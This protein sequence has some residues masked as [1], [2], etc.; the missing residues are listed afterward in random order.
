MLCIFSGPTRTIK[1]IKG[2]KP[3]RLD[4]GECQKN[5]HSKVGDCEHSPAIQERK[6]GCFKL[7]LVKETLAQARKRIGEEHMEAKGLYP[8]VCF[9]KI[10]HGQSVLNTTL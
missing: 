10:W 1:Q 7:K 2:Q 9:P 3:I 8:G 6:E 4:A 5:I